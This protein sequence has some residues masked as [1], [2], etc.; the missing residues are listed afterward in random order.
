M[1][2]GLLA[3]LVILA[4]GLTASVG[5]AAVL[6]STPDRAR[7]ARIALERSSAIAPSSD[8]AQRPAPGTALL[9][10]GSLVGLAIVGRR[11]EPLPVPGSA[12]A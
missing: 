9:V 1:R 7:P 8:P 2:R 12:L 4:L 5:G 11:R 10:S 3:T 6:G